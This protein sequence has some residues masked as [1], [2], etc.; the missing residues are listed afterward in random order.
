M[1]KSYKILVLSCIVI[2]FLNLSGFDFKNIIGNIGN[3]VGNFIENIT[4]NA[5][6]D[7]TEIEVDEN[8]KNE[9]N[10]LFEAIKTSLTEADLD[11]AQEYI[12]KD[13]KYKSNMNYAIEII[14]VIKKFCAEYFSKVSYKIKKV[15][16]KSDG[17]VELR[18]EL[19]APDIARL[20]LSAIPPLISNNIFN[21]NTKSADSQNK[22]AEEV[23][24]IFVDKLKNDKESYKKLVEDFTMVKYNDSYK[25]ESVNDLI[26]RVEEAISS[27]LKKLNME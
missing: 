8:I 7:N 9:F 4:D 18:I 27:V 1:K 12:V 16:E 5:N 6:S 14:P 3:K 17:S 11:S 26:T 21:D 25:I 2:A 22:L 23:F 20:S 19:S 24:K 15:T 13:I 10:D